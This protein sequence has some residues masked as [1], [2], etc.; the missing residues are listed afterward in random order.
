VMDHLERRFSMFNF[1]YSP[2]AS[3]LFGL[4]GARWPATR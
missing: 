3:V 1:D 4:P 2:R